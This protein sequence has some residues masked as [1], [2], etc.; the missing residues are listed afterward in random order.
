MLF[1]EPQIHL[2]NWIINLVIA[3]ECL[4]EDVKNYRY[5]THGNI[6]VSGEG[7]VELYRQLLGALDVIGFTKEE[8][9]C[10]YRRWARS[11]IYMNSWCIAVLVF[12]DMDPRFWFFLTVMVSLISCTIL[13]AFGKAKQCGNRVRF[14]VVSVEVFVEVSVVSVQVF[15]VS[16]E[17]LFT[18]DHNSIWGRDKN[19]LN[20][21]KA[22]EWTRDRR[23][24]CVSHLAA[25]IAVAISN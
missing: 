18:L 21:R 8:Q 5:L 16:V 13:E 4:F 9:L 24:S 17:V 2:V 12:Y 22:L 23:D 19:A 3:E 11:W 25:P 20:A 15:I 14:L 10:E 7:D 1:S 6:P